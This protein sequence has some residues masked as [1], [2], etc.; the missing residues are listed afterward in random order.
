MRN[1]GCEIKDTHKNTCIFHMVKFMGVLFFAYFLH[2]ERESDGG[3]GTIQ[4]IQHI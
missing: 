1:K 2:P 4:L 3:F